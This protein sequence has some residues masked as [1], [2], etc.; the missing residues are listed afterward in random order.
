MLLSPFTVELN[1]GSACY[2]S[3]L[4]EVADCLIL[5]VYFCTLRFVPIGVLFDLLCADPERPWNLIVRLHFSLLLL[6]V[7]LCT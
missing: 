6:Y 2:C 1:N 7:L 4:F 3:I 5:F